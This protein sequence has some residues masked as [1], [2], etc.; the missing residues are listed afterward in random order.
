[1]KKLPFF[2]HYYWVIF[3]TLLFIIINSI[4][5]SNGWYYL[6]LLPALLFII[7]L[8]VISLDK[9]LYLTVLLVPISLPLENYAPQLGFNVQLPTDPIIV[10]IFLL[11]FF[12]I[13]YERS[14]DRAILLHPVS[15]AIYANLLWI[16]ITTLTSSIPLVSFK[17]LI[18]RMWFLVA[19]YFLSTQLF[20]NKSGIQQYFWAYIP[21]MT[22]VICIAMVHLSK[23]GLFNQQVAHLAASPFFNDH[24]SYG[25]VLAML[26]PFAVALAIN[27][28]YS[29]SFRFGSWILV[30]FLSFALMLS[31]SRAAWVSVLVASSVFLVMILKIKF[32]TILI[33]V[34]IGGSLFYVY[35]TD[36][37]LKLEQN[38]QDSSKDLAKHIQSIS[39]IRTDVSNVERLNRWKSAFRM[40]KEHPVLGWGPGT[41]MF[42][43]APFQLFRDKTSISTN[44]GNMGN[45][46][47]EYIGPLAESGI[48]GS[49]TFI[50]ILITTLYTAIKIYSKAQANFHVRLL[51][52]GATLGL[53]TYYTHATLN[54][55]LDTD[56]AS[57][58]F[59]GYTAM[60]VSLDV[61]HVRKLKINKSEVQVL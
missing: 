23:F 33:I 29:T 42:N 46:H 16:F 20:K 57:A 60:I 55:F 22:V 43:Y 26:L 24:T 53:V 44:R 50:L 51:I 15:L 36:I 47:S 8:A 41:Y 58:L 34:A 56:K 18:S 54:N 14:F 61:Y 59:W 35:R 48:L 4:L 25:A 3:I 2:D 52:M 6:S 32:R 17:F 39:N 30:A 11:F 38:R 49:L 31:Y 10:I 7:F 5:C 45:A 21:M 13:I 12:R 19:F 27:R 40:F 28:K 9:L 1:M 37:Y